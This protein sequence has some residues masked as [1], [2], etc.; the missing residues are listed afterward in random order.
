MAEFYVGDKVQV[1]LPRGYSKRGVLGISVLYTTS[2]E[3]RFE[4]ANGVV[5]EI[6]PVGPYSAPQYLVDFRPFDN[7]RLG[8]PWQ[9]HWFRE[10]WLELKERAAAAVAAGVGANAGPAAGGR[11][12]DEDSNSPLHAGAEPGGEDRTPE[13]DEAERERFAA[14]GGP[15][16]PNNVAGA[17]PPRVG[18]PPFG[19]PFDKPD[20]PETPRRPQR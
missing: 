4:G 14:A 19:A 1:A 17:P 3:A 11:G 18:A 7:G 15:P 16:P 9:A 12:S 8:I 20:Q 6:N 2:P 13:Q 10:E 5:T